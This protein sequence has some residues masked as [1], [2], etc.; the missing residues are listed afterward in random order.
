[1]ER[2]ASTLMAKGWIGGVLYSWVAWN[3]VGLRGSRAGVIYVGFE[4]RIYRVVREPQLG[5]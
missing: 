2:V 1:M 4:S 3:R 5:R